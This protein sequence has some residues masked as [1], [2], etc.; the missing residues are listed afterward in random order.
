MSVICCLLLW[1][2]S[3][4][5]IFGWK[6]HSWMTFLHPW[7]RFLH[8]WM[9]FSAVKFLVKIVCIMPKTALGNYC[10]RLL[11]SCKIFAIT[12]PRG[13]WK[14][15]HLNYDASNFY[16]KSDSWKFHP[17]M[18]KSH[19]WMEKCHPWMEE[20]HLWHIAQFFTYLPT[21]IPS[22]DGETSSMDESAICGCHT[23]MERCHP[24]LSSM[25]GEMSSMDE[26]DGWQT[27]TVQLIMK[28]C[29]VWQGVIQ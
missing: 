28:L 12:V 17:W 5:G 24:W 25:D 21:W 19:P 9:E 27:W 10:K 11:N 26:E 14:Q 3:M 2:S 23:W 15:I 8:P 16:Q 7:M 29:K 13:N 18:Q 1:M 22:I 6:S 20:C 4:N